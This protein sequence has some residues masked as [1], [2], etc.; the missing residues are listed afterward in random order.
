[1]L[2]VPLSQSPTAAVNE[3]AALPEPES[4]TPLDLVE[5]VLKDPPT[6]K[7]KTM[8]K[9]ARIG[10]DTG[11]IVDIEGYD[12]VLRRKRDAVFARGAQ[13]AD[14]AY[15]YWRCFGVHCQRH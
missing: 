8:M 6:K 12:C 9:A 13:D 7:P 11:G 4:P 3:G 10:V 1:M 2:R 14:K 15:K 5:G